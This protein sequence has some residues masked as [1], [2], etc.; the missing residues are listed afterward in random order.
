MVAER[1]GG[2]TRAPVKRIADD[3][4]PARIRRIDPDVEARLGDVVIEIEIAD[5]GLDQRVGIALIHFEHPVQPFQV[6]YDAAGIHRSRTAIGEIAP[7]GDGIQ[8]NTVLIG[9]AYD[10]LHLLERRGCHGSGGHALLRLAPIGRVSIA[11]QR[12]ILSAGEDPFRTD[13]RSPGG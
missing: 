5:A 2:P 3:A 11:V 1:R 4:A 9:G 10:R 6:E 13:S 12:H 8:R 7:G